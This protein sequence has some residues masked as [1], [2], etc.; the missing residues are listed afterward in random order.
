VIDV[1]AT[2]LD[3][4][5]LPQQ[6]MSGASFLEGETPALRKIIS[7]VAGSPKKIKP[8]FFQIKTVTITICNKYYS[9]NVQD[10]KFT[11]GSIVSH[12]AR[13]E[14]NLL[15]LDEEIRAEII[16]YLERY[17]YDVSSLR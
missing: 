16:A 17:G 3:Y 10:N 9:L 4:L 2:L 6:W 1:P 5:D 13:C 14:G 7:I 8:P 15:P 11:S 12:T